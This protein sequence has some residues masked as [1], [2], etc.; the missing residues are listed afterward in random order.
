MLVSEGSS[1]YLEITMYQCKHFKAYELVP[2]AL[3]E[4]RGERAIQLLDKE[5]LVAI[6]YVREKLGK[7]TINT[8]KWGG[9]FEYRGIR[10]PECPE[11]SITSQ[12]P[13][14]KA[15]DFDVE[16][17]TS[18][19]VNQWLID[20]RNAPELKGITFIE[21]GMNWTHMDTRPT[22]NDDLVC[23]WTNGNTQVYARKV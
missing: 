11:Y 9:Q 17:M 5:L 15:V 13:Y 4:L 3:Y 22:V 21:M 18:D 23:W 1:F 19:E 2:R 12:H 8:W 16:G 20:N 10:T 14:G 7:V 6:D